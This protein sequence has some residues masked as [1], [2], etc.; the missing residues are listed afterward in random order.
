MGNMADTTL[1]VV[2]IVASRNNCALL[3][4]LHGKIVLTL[5]P[6][7]LNRNKIKNDV[8]GPIIQFWSVKDDY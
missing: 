3:G 5:F 1:V 8:K 2:D 4:A 6:D 7:V